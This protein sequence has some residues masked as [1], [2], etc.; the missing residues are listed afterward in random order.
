VADATVSRR[1]ATGLGA[2]LEVME[3]LGLALGLGPVT[4]TGVADR[5]D[6]AAVG[7]TAAWAT[8]R[9][10]EGRPAEFTP[11]AIRP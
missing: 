7:R 3:V 1:T 8:A 5:G 2:G 4:G 6:A 10:A 11:L 9:G